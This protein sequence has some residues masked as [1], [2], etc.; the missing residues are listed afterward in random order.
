MSAL[1][2]RLRQLVSGE[3]APAP[4]APTAAPS[5]GEGEPAVGSVLS[6]RYLL[7]EPLG[8]GAAGAVYLAQDLVLDHTVAVKVLLLGGLAS[9]VTASSIR[10]DL[11]SEARLAMPLAHPYITRV[12][13]YEVHEAWEYLVMEYVE[14]GTLAQRLRASAERRLPA[15]EVLRYGGMMSE[16]LEYAH[17]L[18]VVHNDLKPG[19]ALL[20]LGEG[21]VKLCDFG[22]ASMVDALARKSDVI[23]GTAGYIAPERLRFEAGTPL[24][25]QYSLA[26]L[27]YHLAEG[28]PPFGQDR[29][30][31]A[32]GH[33]NHTP[34]KAKW[35]SEEVWAVLEKALA[36]RAEERY[37]S[38][39]AMRE[40]L[41]AAQTRAAGT[42][43]P[44]SAVEKN[45]QGR[46]E[47]NAPAEAA[48]PSLGGGVS[49]ETSPRED[50]RAEERGGAE[51]E[52]DTRLSREDRSDDSAR[53][54]KRGVE[55]SRSFRR[56]RSDDSARW[57]KRSEE[58]SR[59]FRR[60]E[61]GGQRALPNHERRREGGTP[62]LAPKRIPEG[63]AII[64]GKAVRAWGQEFAV[65]GFLIDR[66]PVTNIAYL[67]YLEKSGEVCP[68]HWLGKKTALD[69]SEHPVTG[70][71]LE[72][73][74]AYADWAGKRLI[75]ELEWRAAAAPSG[76]TSP[77]GALSCDGSQ[78]HCARA[79][80][81]G[82]AVVSA[83]PRGASP[84]GVLDLIGNVWEWTTRDPRSPPP[85]E[86]Y[87]RVYGG[88]FRHP[89]NFERWPP[90]TTVNVRKSFDYLGF[91]CGKDM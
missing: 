43:A 84:E 4:A 90:E 9:S 27:L 74:M 88:S 37:P 23:G 89:C 13:S 78:C 83:H 87:A 51:R 41:A 3:P 80:S 56:E 76:E 11:R 81:K 30:K 58:E 24:S 42:R 61:S 62:S 19:N 28:T 39:G 71:T 60:E 21:V 63:M 46:Q 73:A 44:G 40:E 31:A 85:E 8:R 5:H 49:P 10:S 72:Q 68:A 65:E 2:S 26:A 38:M 29:H 35:L 66:V 52:R 6:G 22:L 20:P 34:P 54:G 67:K 64:K 86:G 7:R 48:K 12:Y 55:E 50:L 57:G 69:Y 59:S 45:A 16:A 75:S 25:D 47:G 33:L 32:L 36:K 79:K 91:R 17:G 53:W 15:E 1:W 18:G 70:I 77:W 14:G 82:T